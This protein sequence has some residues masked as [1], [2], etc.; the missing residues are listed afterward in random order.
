MVNLD[1]QGL[2]R[3]LLDLLRAAH[4][5]LTLS[6]E[7]E[8]MLPFLRTGDAVRIDLSAGASD[9]CV[10]DIVAYYSTSAIAVHRVLHKTFKQ[11]QVR[12][13]QA[14]DN[15]VSG[16]WLWEAEVLGK[17]VTVIR[18]DAGEINL[19]TDCLPSVSTCR[20]RYFRIQIRARRLAL[21][22]RACRPLR[23]IIS[24]TARENR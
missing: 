8:S 18:Q 14:G 3:P 1:L 17:V 5:T 7:G 9:I 12:L 23:K 24:F 22:E 11:G 16:C 4:K 20:L 6:V 15:L 13:Y 21:M 10:G 19:T 2:R